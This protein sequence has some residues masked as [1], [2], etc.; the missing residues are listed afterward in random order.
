MDIFRQAEKEYYSREEYQSNMDLFKQAEKE[1]LDENFCCK[2]YI[3]DFVLSGEE[4]YEIVRNI[5]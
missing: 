4:K 1:Y 5:N 3:T 2:R